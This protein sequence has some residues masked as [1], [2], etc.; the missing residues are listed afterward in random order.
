MLLSKTLLACAT[1]IVAQANAFDFNFDGYFDFSADVPDLFD[2]CELKNFLQF[3]SDISLDVDLFKRDN[4]WKNEE[5]VKR[6][7]NVPLADFTVSDVAKVESDLFKV[8]INFEAGAS[9]DLFDLFGSKAGTA[10]VNNLGVDGSKSTLV[11]GSNAEGGIENLFQWSATVLVKAQAKGDGLFCLPDD[12]SIDFE[13]GAGA[14]LNTTIVDAFKEV[15]PLDFSYGL[16]SNIDLSL[17]KE[18]S[19]RELEISNAVKKSIGERSL[20]SA[21]SAVGSAVSDFDLDFLPL[22]A[23]I[24]FVLPNFCW[25]DCDSSDSSSVE[26]TTTIATSSAVSS[27]APSS[28]APV[29][30]APESS[31]EPTTVTVTCTEGG[32][33]ESTSVAPD[34]PVV[35][36]TICPESSSVAPETTAPVSTTVVTVTSCEDDKCTT[37]PVTTGVTTVCDE[38]TSYTTYCPLST[39]T[40]VDTTVV[41]VTSCEN[42]KCSTAPVT[43]GVTTVT[44]ENTVYTTYCPIP[45]TSKPETVKPETSKPAST[46][47]ETVKPET[48]KPETVKPE[49][50]KPTTSAPTTAAPTTAAPTDSLSTKTVNSYVTESSKGGNGTVAPEVSTYEGYANAFSVSLGT[51]FAAIFVV[52]NI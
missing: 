44:E 26:S 6:D 4:Y 32:E 18:V 5:I 40:D 43:T 29:S 35:T 48:S 31:A 52:F 7:D 19:K 50:V 20:S 47:P 16:D 21:G 10:S 17:G 11:V 39:T 14:Q 25:Y 45:E 30:S 13:L 23:P 46:K 36:T 9:A 2:I 37:A 28:S 12:F 1:T 24:P 3:G 33:C 27:A 15:F 38:T 34:C 42:D 41:T 51:V 8:T 49:T 22:L